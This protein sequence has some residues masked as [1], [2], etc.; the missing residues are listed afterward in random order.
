[1]PHLDLKGEGGSHAALLLTGNTAGKADGGW[2]IDAR[3]CLGWAHLWVCWRRLW[4]AAAARQ[5]S[6]TTVL[7]EAAPS[8]T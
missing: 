5:V 1:M 7:C 2:V 8:L 3:S 6:G 4:E